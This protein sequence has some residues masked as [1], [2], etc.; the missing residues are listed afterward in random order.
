VEEQ[1]DAYW[2]AGADGEFFA[3]VSGRLRYLAA[4]RADFPAVGDWVAI[5]S[6]PGD[7]QATIHA[8]LPRTSVLS[9]KAAG[10]ETVQ[11]IIAANVDTV[12]IVT[13][14]NRDL[15]DRRLE[16]YIAMV[17][18]S[19]AQP[20]ILLNKSDLVDNA[21]EVAEGTRPYVA[22]APV[23]V[24]SAQTGAGIDAL[25]GYLGKGR[26]V[27]LVGSSGVGKSTLIN[28]LLGVDRLKVSDV[29][30]KDDRGRH[31]TTTRQMIALPHGGLLIDTPGMREISLWGEEGVEQ[32]FPEITLLAAQ[33]KFTDCQHQESDV[34]CAIQKALESEE[35]LQERW[36]A[37]LKLQKEAA[38]AARRQDKRAALDYKKKSKKLSATL[39]KIVAQK[40]GG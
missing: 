38:Y 27:C 33:C 30:E 36:D 6:R 32:A 13:S 20:V 34:A 12:F 4:G 19:G 2:V 23:H 26:T 40:R 17:S 8:V 16:R 1:R 10:Q 9:R 5:E 7:R 3:E 28:R 39:K 22:G 18:E 15:N 11:Q 35:L 21:E 29:R 25:E 37:Y 24:T 31:T 14:L